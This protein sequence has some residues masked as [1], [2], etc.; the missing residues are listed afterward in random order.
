MPVSVDSSLA[1]GG[2]R[3]GMPTL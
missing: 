3:K 2:S 1:R